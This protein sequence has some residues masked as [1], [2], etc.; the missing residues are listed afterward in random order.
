MAD[1]EARALGAGAKIRIDKDTEFTLS[2]VKLR[3]LA[4]LQRAAVDFYKAEYLRTYAKNIHLFPKEKQEALLEKKVEEAA[5]WD[6]KDLP[7]KKS[8]SASNIKVTEGLK[9]RLR[10]I[11]PGDEK[12]TDD[13]FKNLLVAALDSNQIDS[14]EVK[15]LTGKKPL[16]NPVSYDMWWITGSYE[17]MISFVFESVRI[18]HPRVKK[19]DI[20]NW[21]IAKQVEAAQI[22]ENITQPDEG[23]I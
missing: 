23:N 14:G 21:P 11:Y 4:E 1:K 8:Y 16:Q 5:R 20:E 17:G 12:L 18:Q 3:Q 19:S 15:E 22:I 9:S 13:Q 7:P 6:I 10:E 2:P